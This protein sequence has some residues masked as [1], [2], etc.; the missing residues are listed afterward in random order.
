[1]PPRRWTTSAEHAYL[2]LQMPDYIRRQAQKKLY[3][4][5]PAMI[6]GWFQQFP[7]YT[8][9][10]LPN[11]NVN[12]GTEAETGLT[13]GERTVLGKA[14]EERK[15]QL[16][17]WFRREVK[18]V[19]QGPVGVKAMTP[20]AAALMKKRARRGLAFG[21][22]DALALHAASTMPSTPS[23]ASE[24]DSEVDEEC[25]STP[26]KPKR[27]RKPKKK[28]MASGSSAGGPGAPSSAPPPSS[29]GP[30]ASSPVSAPPCS[31]S[32]FP[33]DSESPP[34]PVSAPGSIPVSHVS[35]NW[36]F[37][38]GP[39]PG[40][41]SDV[42]AFSGDAETAAVTDW[43]A[44]YESG[45]TFDLGAGFSE[46]SDDVFNTPGGGGGSLGFW[47]SADAVA[48]GK[49]LGNSATLPSTHAEALPLNVPAAS[50]A[51]ALV[52]A[53]FEPPFLPP[54]PALPSSPSSLPLSLPPTQR[55]AARPSYKGAAFY[56]PNANA[57][58]AG[59][60]IYQPSALFRAFDGSTRTPSQPSFAIG[61]PASLRRK[62]SAWGSPARTPLLTFGGS[63]GT[64]E[65]FASHTARAMA[66][67]VGA[68]VP[69]PSQK[70]EAHKTAA[71]KTAPAG[72]RNDE[73]DPN[74]LILP[75][76]RPAACPPPP[77]K[78]RKGAKSPQ[79]DDGNDGPVLPQSRPVARKPAAPKE[80]K[81]AGAVAPKRKEV[82]EPQTE[83][84]ASHSE[85]VK[86]PR[87]RPPK[88]KVPVAATTDAGAGSA[89]ASAGSANAGVGAALGD[90]TNTPVAA[91]DS[92]AG[93][94]RI[95]KAKKMYDGTFAPLVA[96][97]PAADQ[98]APS[99]P[100]KKA[101]MKA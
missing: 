29:P 17:S 93:T 98:A 65:G 57:G 7:E 58:S 41:A 48:W 16:R 10:G 87:G 47:N 15:K 72:A 66:H 19:R 59:G 49:F 97:R 78:A 60:S 34:P 2:E 61:S 84:I 63:R 36:V 91:A 83:G 86:K 94:G 74:A 82:E 6:E 18:K 69:P 33:R 35:G 64:A 20:L 1:M 30:S 37:P 71:A 56:D 62:A 45:G 32:F 101:R 67:I 13:N 3:L 75:Q 73:E 55:P 90:T 23:D 80:K 26:K 43:D 40:P 77:P 42:L 99:K 24:P 92:E 12:A 76:S 28:T 70:P 68:P 96:K 81:H 5:W 22:R 89:S 4:F 27:V 95:R 53:H 11:P 79:N 44:L 39:I 51:G 50:P 85:V 38:P 31:P 100:V 54:L 52:P 88:P 25:P 8:R 21:V 9:L 46:G 14:I